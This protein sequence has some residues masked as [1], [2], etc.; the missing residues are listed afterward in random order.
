MGLLAIALACSDSGILAADKSP[1]KILT[2]RND[3]VSVRLVGVPLQEIVADI[4][5]ASGA[6]VYGIVRQ[7]RDVSAEFDDVPLAIIKT[8]RFDVAELIQRPGQTGCGILTAGKQHKGSVW[9]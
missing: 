1:R 5:Q 3:H 4:G 6:A 9:V 2:Y 7:P 8:N